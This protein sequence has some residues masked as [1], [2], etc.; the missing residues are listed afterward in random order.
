MAKDIRKPCRYYGDFSLK[1][2]LIL[3]LNKERKKRNLHDE[4][5]IIHWRDIVGEYA[6]NMMPCKIIFDGKDDCF[7]VKKILICSTINRQF[8]VEFIFHKKKI[9]DMLNFYF[10]NAK[11]VF[12]D[13]KLKVI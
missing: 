3:S 9:I 4:R 7:R 10:G 8:A 1:E 12:S 11:S 5:L 2:K 13:I 6:D